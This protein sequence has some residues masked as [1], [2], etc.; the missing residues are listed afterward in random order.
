MKNLTILCFLILGGVFLAG[1][2]PSSSTPPTEE[3]CGSE[4]AK[5]VEYTQDSILRNWPSNFIDD[6]LRVYNLW[7]PVD[8][9]CSKKHISSLH[10]VK[11]FPYSFERPFYFKAAI[12]WSIFFERT[13]QGGLTFSQ[14]GNETQVTWVADVEDVGMAQSFGEGPAN[15]FV[16]IYVSFRTFGNAQQDSMYFVQ[17]FLFGHNT[18]V[19]NF[20]KSSPADE[21]GLTSGKKERITLVPGKDEKTFYPGFFNKGELYR[22]EI[23]NK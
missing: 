12:E 2:N 4:T 5:R 11:M 8:S 22:K 15:V 7:I 19:Y 1:C 14:I 23:N 13:A 20:H 10:Q 6:S 18:L 17:R 21:Q 16:N 3:D 9:I